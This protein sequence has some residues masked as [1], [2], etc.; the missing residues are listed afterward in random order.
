M[1]LSFIIQASTTDVNNNNIVFNIRLSVSSSTSSRIYFSVFVEN[2]AITFIMIIIYITI[3]QLKINGFD[4]N[5]TLYTKALNMYYLIQNM[6]LYSILDMDENS[7]YGKIKAKEVI[8]L[9][10]Q[11][12]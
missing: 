4:M 11:K 10:I 9:T 8:I 2:I 12:W 3:T 6:I 5:I 7:N 1:V